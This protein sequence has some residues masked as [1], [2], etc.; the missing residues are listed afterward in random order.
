MNIF[1]RAM[2]LSSLSLSFFCFASEQLG[3]NV[4]ARAGACGWPGLGFTIARLST[5]LLSLLLFLCFLLFCEL[6]VQGL[7]E[8]LQYFFRYFQVLEDT[9]S[10]KGR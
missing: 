7:L 1:S 10:K 5:V 6:N 8:N 9:F 2:F 3:V 4:A